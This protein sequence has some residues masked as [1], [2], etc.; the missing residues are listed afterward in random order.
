MLLAGRPEVRLT[1][2]TSGAY[3]GW[4]DGTTVATSP[5][6]AYG[7]LNINLP[8]MPSGLTWHYFHQTGTSIYLIVSGASYT[9]PDIRIVGGA[10]DTTISPVSTSSLSGG[11][12]RGDYTGVAS[13]ILQDGVTYTLTVV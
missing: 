5:N 9:M 1:A 11:I 7:K 12:N 2:D 10:T 3:V 6:A 4:G 13:N 8:D